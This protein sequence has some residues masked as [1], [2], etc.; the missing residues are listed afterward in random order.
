MGISA[1]IHSL[2]HSFNTLSASISDTFLE[3]EGGIK[4]LASQNF[5]SS[6]AGSNAGDQTVKKREKYTVGQEVTSA[7]GQA[8]QERGQ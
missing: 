8:S 2:I 6:F 1:L 5:H 7:W 4:S 3:V